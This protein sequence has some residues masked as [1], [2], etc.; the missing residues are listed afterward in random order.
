MADRIVIED[1]ELVRKLEDLAQSQQRSVEEVIATLLGHRLPAS[2]T[3]QA[4]AEDLARQV[5]LGI[6]QRAR[7]IWLEHGIDEKAA[8][9]D[10]ELDEHFW[11]F[12][13]EGYPRLKSEQSEIQI[14]EGSLRHAGRILRRS[15]F[16][17]G[18]SDIAE[19]SQEILRDEYTDY[20]IERMNRQ[21]PD[22][23]SDVD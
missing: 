9:T 20:L 2:P 16:R 7:R 11:A 10:E 5:R 19:R 14:P 6:Y 17:S 18:R 4:S 21:A 8:M 12:D 23:Q 22:A 1:Q 13:P 15:E 3:Q